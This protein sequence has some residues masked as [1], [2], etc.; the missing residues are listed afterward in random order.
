MKE[1][2]PLYG[3]SK[4]V[5]LKSDFE[6]NEGKKVLVAKKKKSGSLSA[7]LGNIKKEILITS[8]LPVKVI[9]PDDYLHLPVGEIFKLKLLGGTGVYDFD[10]NHEVATVSNINLLQAK[11]V[12]DLTV[13][14]RDRNHLANSAIFRLKVSELTEI[15]SL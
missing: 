6:L 1:G 8:F 3:E 14:V 13:T 9:L 12:G 10:I 4:R 2:E 15:Q 7:Q 5:V 11:S